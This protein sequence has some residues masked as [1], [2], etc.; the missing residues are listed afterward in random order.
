MAE[1]S[2]LGGIYCYAHQKLWLCTCGSSGNDTNEPYGQLKPQT[3]PAVSVLLEVL[4]RS[5]IFIIQGLEG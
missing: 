1:H 5:G 2:G 3:F 4:E